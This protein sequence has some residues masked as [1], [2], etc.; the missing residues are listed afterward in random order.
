[1]KEMPK[2]NKYLNSRFIARFTMVGLIFCLII[3]Q[4][5]LAQPNTTA[6]VRRWKVNGTMREA[7]IYVPLSAKTKP[8]PVTFLFHGHGGNMQDMFHDHTFE[9]LWPEAIIVVPQGLMTPGTLV[10]REGNRSGWQQSLGDQQDRDLH[11][12]DTILG[13]LEKECVVD[14]SRIYVTGHSNGA[15]FVYLLWANRAD[16]LAAVAASAAA[17]TQLLAQ[18]KPKPVMQIIGRG[19]RL[20]KP[21]WQLR[22]V[23]S[24]RQLNQCSSPGQPFANLA[25]MYS[26]AVGSPMVVYVHP[27][28]H[29]YPA[30]ADAL[31]IS[32]FKGIKKE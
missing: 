32:F 23:R 5:M 4:H 20:V 21:A 10:D 22:M 12:F 25:T 2:P 16:A 19:D 24:F 28:G 7:M 15:K 30:T 17:D 14:K 9:K 18:L 6:G 26:S 13:S 31:V 11:F 1:M 27:G 8:T 29:V 3:S